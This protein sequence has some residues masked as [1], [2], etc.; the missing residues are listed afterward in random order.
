MSKY[1]VWTAGEDITA[2]KISAGLTEIIVADADQTVN[3]STTLV[4]STELICPLA[5]NSLYEV[6]FF[7]CYNSGGATA[8]FRTDWD[9]PAGATGNKWALGLSDS[10]SN[11]TPEGI[12]R[13]GVH[14]FATDITYG[15]R[16]ATT[17]QIFAMEGGIIT[18]TTAG[19]VTLRFAQGTAQAVDTQLKIGSYMKVTRL[20]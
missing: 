9:V 10:V 15:N 4:S 2:D 6:Q 12:M 14:G 17:N 13:S 5:A 20:L 16:G 18:V 19:N 11:A 3:N 7:I 1:P 8:D